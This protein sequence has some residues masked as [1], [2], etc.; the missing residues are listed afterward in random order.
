MKKFSNTLMI[1]IV[2]INISDLYLKVYK[3]FTI[4]AIYAYLNI[5][6]D[7]LNVPTRRILYL[8]IM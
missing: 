8:Q 4:Y 5:K 2:E 6:S 3:L 7:L 1:L